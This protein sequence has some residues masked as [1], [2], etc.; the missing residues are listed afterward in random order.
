MIIIPRPEKSPY[1]YDVMSL[2]GSILWRLKRKKEEVPKWWL[3]LGTLA[4]QEPS[5]IES[6]RG[7]WLLGGGSG[8]GL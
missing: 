4:Q 1:D 2:M 5:I 8:S 7:A 3:T 6:K